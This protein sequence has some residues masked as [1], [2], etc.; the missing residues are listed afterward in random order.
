MRIAIA[1]GHG[2]IGQ[3]LIRRLVERGDEIRSIDRNPDY[4]DELRA[5]GA[6]PVICDLESATEEDV[7]SAVGSV[8]AIIFSAGAGPGSGPDRKW[9]MDYGGV[10]KLIEAAK[11]NAVRRFLLVSSMGADPNAHGEDTF[12]VY[13]RAKGKADAELQ[14]SG[15]DYTIVRPTGLTDDPG[16][17]LVELGDRVGS[18]RIPRDDVAAILVASLD[19]TNAIGKTF[20]AR[21][22]NTPIEEAIASL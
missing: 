12:A 7:A 18:G 13:L 4:A 21:S 19:A 3:R 9:T 2:K 16:T 14:S 11:A 6:K 22:G 15:L 17:G 8:D 20:E 10:V 1:G 5:A